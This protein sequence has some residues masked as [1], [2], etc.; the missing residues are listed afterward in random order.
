[1]LLADTREVIYFLLQGMLQACSGTCCLY[2]C[3]L[4][5]GAGLMSITALLHG[6]RQHRSQQDL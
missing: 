3:A 1:M 6:L 2:R 4:E 5:L